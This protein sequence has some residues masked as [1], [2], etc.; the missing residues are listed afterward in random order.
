MGLWTIPYTKIR[1]LPLRYSFED[2]NTARK[3]PPEEGLIFPDGQVFN[4]AAIFELRKSARIFL[5]FN[6]CGRL[7]VNQN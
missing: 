6:L 7:L 3:S 1:S 5:R 4:Q 2:R